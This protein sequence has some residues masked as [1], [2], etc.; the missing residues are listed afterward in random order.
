[1]GNGISIAT[2]SRVAVCIATLLIVIGFS[3][4]AF[5]KGGHSQWPELVFHLWFEHC[6]TSY[7]K[8]FPIGNEEKGW[9][10]AICHPW[11]HAPETLKTE[12]P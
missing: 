6:H 2:R 4:P 7:V 8:N 11:E 3:S 5:A 12:S 10:W 1:V 9:S